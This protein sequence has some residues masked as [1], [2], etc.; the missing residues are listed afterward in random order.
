M[1]PD[2]SSPGYKHFLI[3][4]RPGGGL[5]WVKGTYDSIRGR[6]SSEWRIENGSLS[7]DLL[8]PPNTSATV[9]IPGMD[10]SKIEESGKS[11]RESVGVKFVRAVD[12]SSVFE[13]SSGSFHFRGPM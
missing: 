7:L 6:I 5:T 8:V 2:E 4:P 13:V 1:S 11:V 3:H 9:I 10:S 12:G